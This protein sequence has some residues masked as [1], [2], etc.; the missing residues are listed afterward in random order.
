MRIQSQISNGVLFLLIAMTALG[1]F[2]IDAYLPALPS[3]SHD[4]STSES[5]VQ[6]TLASFLLGLA[7]G[8][9]IIGPLSDS[10]GRR[11]VIIWGLV[12]YIGSSIICATTLNVEYL[13]IFR[14]FQAVSVAAVMTASSAVLADVYSGD[15]LSKKSSLLYVFMSIAPMIAPIIG[16]QINDLLGWQAIFWALVVISVPLMI[17]S[18]IKIP[19]TLAD[20]ERIKFSPIN[21]IIGYMKLLSNVST[22][23]YAISAGSV[24]AIFFAYVAATPF[25]YIESYGMSEEYFAYFFAFGAVIAILANWIN[26]LLVDKIGYKKMLIVQ[27]V[28]I[29]LVGLLLIIGTLG[30][31]DRWAIYAA[32]FLMMG[33]MHIICTNTLTGIMNDTQQKGTASALMLSSRF[34]GGMLGVAC[35]SALQGTQQ[36]NYGIILLVFALIS[37]ISIYIGVKYS[38]N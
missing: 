38:T 20:H 27:S 11:S 2:S 17:S 14:F 23:A 9:I 36:L 33:S 4:L 16:G 24:S 10:F 32:G 28:F 1:P 6:L 7:I 31:A 12:G 37:G 13:I 5:T 29:V 34:G 21:S 30:F 19:E 3:I 22:V 26:I 25:I 15:E 8:P 18:Y 35:I